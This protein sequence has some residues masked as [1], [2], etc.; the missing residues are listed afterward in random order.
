MHKGTLQIMDVKRVRLQMP[1]KLVPVLQMCFTLLPLL[2]L[3]PWA[4]QTAG[5]I[6]TCLGVGNNPS[7]HDLQWFDLHVLLRWLLWILLLAN[8]AVLMVDGHQTAVVRDSL[9]W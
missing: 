7:V 4:G 1:T 8:I 5:Q 6:W 3:P 9:T 2:Y